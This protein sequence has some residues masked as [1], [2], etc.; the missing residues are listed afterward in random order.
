MS[1]AGGALSRELTRALTVALDA[2]LAEDASLSAVRSAQDTAQ[3]LGLGGLEKL[4]GCLVGQVGR[5]RPADMLPAIVRVKALAAQCATTGTLEPFQRANP[6]LASAAQSLASLESGT[7]IL[8]NGSQEIPTLN[9]AEVLEDLPLADDASRVRARDMRVTA[10][11]AAALRAALDW[12]EKEAPSPRPLKISPERSVVDVVCTHVNHAGMRAAEKVLSVVGGVLFPASVLGPGV[13][14]SGSWIVRVPSFA[15][16]NSYLMLD[17][18]DLSIAIPWH[19]VLRLYMVPS[20]ELERGVSGLGT[21][22]L[23]PI[24]PPARSRGEH[25]IALIGHGLK[26]AYLIADRLVWRLEAEP[27]ET[28]ESPSPSYTLSGAV[29][30]DEDETYWVVDPSR[31]LASVERPTIAP[32]PP[33]EPKPAL[34]VLRRED[35]TP[36][37]EPAPRRAPEPMASVPSGSPAGSPATEIVAIEPAA[38]MAVAPAPEVAEPAAPVASP[39]PIVAPAPVP[40]PPVPHARPR[41]ALIA[42]DSIAARLFLTRMLERENFEVRAVTTATELFDELVDDAWSLVLVDIEL[43]DGRDEDVFKRVIG[44]LGLRPTPPPLVALVRDSADVGVARALGVTRTLRKPFDR[45]SLVALLEI[46][47]LLPK[48]AR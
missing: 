21:P 1:T 46:V 25:P 34:P 36:L 15:G 24:R 35:V 18:G 45:E 37:P 31:A 26:R 38:A 27:V 11:V 22:V 19:A 12:L 4:L 8:P 7:Q 20:I 40:A 43:P 17:Q 2:A 14:P 48:G 6:E 33:Q 32:A 3:V 29:R 23:D 39:A 30:T 47:G 5:P 10:P 13:A 28:P 41:R 9:V 42:E 16:R 44:T